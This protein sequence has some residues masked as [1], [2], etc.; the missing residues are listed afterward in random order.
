MN[1]SSKSSDL[2]IL[3]DVNSHDLC[4]D[5]HMYPYSIIYDYLS[6]TEIFDVY[7]LKRDN[8][9]ACVEKNIFTLPFPDNCGATDSGLLDAICIQNNI[10]LCLSFN[11]NIPHTIPTILSILPDFEELKNKVEVPWIN[12]K[13]REAIWYSHSVIFFDDECNNHIKSMCA[14]NLHTKMHDISDFSDNSRRPEIRLSETFRNL[15]QDTIQ[16]RN[17]T[18][19]SQFFH[20]WTR[21]RKLQIDVDI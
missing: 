2:K 16:T 5:T 15:L 14:S 10:D 9:N 8:I 11:Y 12:K 1:S 21:L 13:I 19:G 20:Q 18:S 7:V 6:N 4:K 3:I 17:S